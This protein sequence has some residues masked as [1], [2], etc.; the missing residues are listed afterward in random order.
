MIKKSLLGILCVFLGLIAGCKRHPDAS[1]SNGYF[2]TSYQDECRFI[3]E[4]IVSDIAEQIYF[5]KFHQLP[6]ANRFNVIAIETPESAFE[7]PV[8]ALQIDLDRSHAGLKA[9]LNINGPIWSPEI[10]DALAQQLAQAVG[11]PPAG[12]SVGS[13]DT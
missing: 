4:T 10:Y 9:K 11:L 8:Y 13:K 3:V 1:A 2:K 5:A 7:T 12:D 6:D